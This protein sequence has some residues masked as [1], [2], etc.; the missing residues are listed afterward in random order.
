MVDPEKGRATPPRRTLFRVDPK[1]GG[2]TLPCGLAIHGNGK[3]VMSPAT[4]AV[5]EHFRA[6]AI[7]YRE[8]VP[9]PSGLLGSTGQGDVVDIEPSDNDAKSG[10]VR[11]WAGLARRLGQVIEAPIS[12]GCNESWRG[13]RRPPLPRTRGQRHVTAP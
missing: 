12:P 2:G 7:R 1:G 3:D 11:A 5:I 4:R 6:V 13:L 9:L 8:R 10:I